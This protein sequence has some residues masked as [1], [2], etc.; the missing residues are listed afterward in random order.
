MVS[1]GPFFSINPHEVTAR[2]T[3]EGLTLSVRVGGFDGS[4]QRKG[5]RITHSRKSCGR[6]TLKPHSR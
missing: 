5:V 1:G 2:H 4:G 6:A 3:A